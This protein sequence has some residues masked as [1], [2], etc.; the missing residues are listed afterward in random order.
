[1]GGVKLKLV[2]N[3]FNLI[4]KGQKMFKKF[5]KFQLKF[6]SIRNDKKFANFQIQFS[7]SKEGPNT[8]S[9]FI[10]TRMYVRENVWEQK[11]GPNPPAQFIS[12]QMYVREQFLRLH[13]KRPKY[14]GWFIFTRMYVERNFC[15]CFYYFRCY[16]CKAALGCLARSALE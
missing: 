8:P 14:A 10:S 15:G 11:K 9:R 13:E 1:M 4:Q 3:Y 2:W 12:M 7:D 16:S 5:D 6:R